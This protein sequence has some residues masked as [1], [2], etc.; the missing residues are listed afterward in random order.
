MAH[1]IKSIDIIEDDDGTSIEILVI[2]HAVK[3]LNDIEKAEFKDE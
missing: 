3:N 1:G 2:S